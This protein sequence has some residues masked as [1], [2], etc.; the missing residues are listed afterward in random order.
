MKATLEVSGRAAMSRWLRQVLASKRKLRSELAALPFSKKLKLL[1]KLR[2][3]SLAL[4][5]NPLRN[6]VARRG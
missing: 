1:E 3:R 2:A 5:A 4:A 6:P